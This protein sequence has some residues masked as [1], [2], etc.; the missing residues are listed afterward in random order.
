MYRG[1]VN[2]KKIVSIIINFANKNIFINR[3][4]KKMYTYDST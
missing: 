2:N 1:K 4:K 3:L